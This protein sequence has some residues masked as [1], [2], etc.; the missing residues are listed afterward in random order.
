LL[1]YYHINLFHADFDLIFVAYTGVLASVGCWE[2]WRPSPQGGSR[3]LQW[4]D[5]DGRPPRGPSG[6]ALL[7]CV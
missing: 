5:R 6:S 4:S 7:L 1:L 3:S 2:V